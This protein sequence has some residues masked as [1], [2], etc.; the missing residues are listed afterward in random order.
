M[1][2]HRVDQI[3][4]VQIA[5]TARN[6]RQRI[7]ADDHLADLGHQLGRQLLLHH[8][9]HAFLV[10]QHV[11]IAQHDFL[12]QYVAHLVAA[13]APDFAVLA[14]CVTLEAVFPA[15]KVERVALAITM[16]AQEGVNH[17]QIIK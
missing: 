15:L 9:Q 2:V 16:K 1:R 17:T 10:R 12:R 13:I 7:A 6:R 14:R 5:H 8:A 3:V 11:Q 4:K